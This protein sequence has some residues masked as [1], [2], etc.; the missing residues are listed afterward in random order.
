MS[1]DQPLHASAVTAFPEYVRRVA[2]A[3]P[4]FI[5][6][7]EKAVQDGESCFF[8]PIQI[9]ALSEFTAIFGNAPLTEF[10]IL[11][12]DEKTTP[13]GIS[14][15]EPFTFNGNTV[16][17][18]ATTV[19]YRLYSGILNY[20]GNAGDS[21]Y[22]ISIG[23]FD[24]TI[25]S[26]Q[27]TAVFLKALECLCDFYGPTLVN[28]PDAV[29]LICQE[30]S[31]ALEKYALCFMVQTALIEHCANQK[32]RLALLDVPGGFSLAGTE[33]ITE[34]ITAFRN[35][36]SPEEI[37]GFAAAYYPWIQTNVIPEEAIHPGYFSSE[38]FVL[39][40][41][42]LL[43]LA[44]NDAELRIHLDHFLQEKNGTP[45]MEKAHQAFLKIG[46]YHDLVQ[47]I[48]RNISLT[49]PCA[50]VAGTYTY[51]DVNKG[52]WYAPANIG[53][54]TVTGVPVM[55]TDQQQGTILNNPSD[56]KAVC[57][58]RTF[59]GKGTLIWGGRTLDSNS[60]DW[61]Y[62]QVR[63]TIIFI[64]QS[65]KNTLREFELMPNAPATWNIIHSLVSAFLTD[66]WQQGALIGS[67]S[68][69]AFNL[70]LDESTTTPTDI[71]NGIL[72]VIIKVALQR[73]EE[74]I[75]ISL[76]QSMRTD[77]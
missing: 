38:L 6:Y 34:L 18:S 23:T 26:L 7:T 14:P 69:D 57:A 30:A 46:F 50:A 22:V 70:Y 72:N 49:P 75:V 20:F 39:L 5:G 61:R 60:F 12:T 77:D 32:D 64:E 11:P 68:S 66:L 42:Q 28:I 76:Q 44:E 74:Y 10:T 71:E 48:S 1:P 37:N 3:I 29:E 59:A 41:E 53:F 43:P 40:R 52:V 56:G 36:I 21:C 67:K 4:V 45:Q 19:N 16:K 24:Y 27:N 54:N 15:Y 17:I 55:I 35:G 47:R 2:T 31:N 13:G 63:R 58:I 51:N 8:Q 25:P 65:I 33:K 73:P 62:I 9:N